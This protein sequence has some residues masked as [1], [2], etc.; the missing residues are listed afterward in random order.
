MLVENKFFFIS[1]PRSASTAFTESCI[2]SKFDI[3]YVDSRFDIIYEND[4]V[5]QYVNV[6][7]HDNKNLDA[8]FYKV[9]NEK[10]EI[11]TNLF[12]KKFI[13]SNLHERLIHMFDRF[14]Y[15][16]PIIAIKRQKLDRFISTF[17]KVLEIIYDLDDKESYE[18]LKKVSHQDLFCFDRNLILEEKFEEISKIVIDELKLNRKNEEL[19]VGTLQLLF[20]PMSYYHN[21][22]I[23]IK[24]FDLYD[25]DSLLEMEE[26]VKDITKKNFK[27]IKSNKTP[28]HIEH[29]LKI[30]EDFKYFY[31]S[32]YSETEN[33]KSLKTLL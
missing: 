25:E 20:K 17:Q 13:I 11:D 26:W 10:M 14:G 2:L 32:I 33:H 8:P 31:D 22:N 24:W 3:K 28:K 16:Y 9:T 5:Y 15:N 21:N 4:K 1:L 19:L 18:K 30:T 27:L 23:N 12:G 6:W 29:S 7:H